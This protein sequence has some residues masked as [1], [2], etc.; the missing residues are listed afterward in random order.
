M[1]FAALTLATDGDVATLTL[2]R[3]ERRNALSLECLREIET[4]L[5]AVAAGPAR[6]LVI[7]ANGPAFSAGHDLTEMTERR[8][9]AF[10]AD[11]VGTCI[12]VMTSL[13]EMPQPVIAKVDG[14]ATAAGCQLVAACDLAVASATS[15]FATPGV[16]I[17][18]FCSTPMVPVQ[19]AVGTKR[20]LELLLTGDMIDAAT[21]ETWGLVNRV[22]PGAE[23]DAA[24]ADLTARLIRSSAHVLAL[25]KRAF[26]AQ[27][28][29]T[30]AAAYALACPVMVENAADPDALEGMRAF[31]AKRAPQWT[32]R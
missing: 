16:N 15:R 7:A 1:D 9:E 30:E 13:H 18:L 25:G 27:T 8:D 19:R 2:D 26:W 5:A 32:T 11:L 29:L 6:V 17:G 4:A 12:R 20:A 31:L 14:V 21:A 3:P 10:L 22:V 23:L 28:G 24:V